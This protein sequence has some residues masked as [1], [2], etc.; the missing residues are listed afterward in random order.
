MKRFKDWGMSSKILILFGGMSVAI[1]AGMLFYFLPSVTTS[2]MDEKRQA[3]SNTVDVA[4]ALVEEFGE[5]ARSGK[6]DRQEAMNQAAKEVSHLRYGGNE[7]FWINDLKP[8]MINHPIKPAL[9]GKDLSG[10]K[11]ENGVFP[12]KEMANVSREKGKGYVEYVWPKPGSTQPQP[13]ISYVKL[14]KPWGWVVG[15]GIYVDDVYA[16]INVMRMKMLIPTVVLLVIIFGLVLMVVRSIVSPLQHAVDISERMSQGDLSMEVPPS[17][18]DEAGQVLRSMRHMVDRLKQIVAEVSQAAE[19]VTG[20]SEELASASMELSQGASTQASA[21]EEVSASMEEMTSSIS[22]NASNAKTTDSIA[23]KASSDTAKGGEA[24]RNTVTAMKEIA[25]K[26]LIVEEI[27]RQTNLLA[28]NAAIEAARAGEH[29]K[30]FAVVAAEVRKLAERSGQAAAEISELSSDSMQVAEEA[31]GLL[32]RIVP[33]INKT[34]ELV[35]EIASASD[36]QNA[37]AEQVNTGIQDLNKVVQ[38]NA[39]A[40]EEVASTAEELSS[41]AEL[42]QDTLRFF[43][44]DRMTMNM[45]AKGQSAGGKNTKTTMKTKPKA[46]S[47]KAP[48]SSGGKSQVQDNGIDLTMDDEDFER[49]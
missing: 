31:G 45:L 26:I 33:D 49:F 23:L 39:S 10:I 28:L 21:V 42:L 11:D 14:Y 35:Q 18:G 38:Q 22:Q 30:G 12:F 36:D 19:N 40:S 5:L 47:G 4:Y 15:S 8:V 46:L 37:G 34:A 48:A 44:L 20:G 17:N 3:L 1:L 7:Y 13:K 16:Q 25:E 24:V 2:L 41:Q 6:M 27:A 43:K 32:E 9:N 29:G